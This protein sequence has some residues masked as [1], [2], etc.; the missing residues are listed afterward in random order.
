MS[1]GKITKNRESFP[2]DDTLLKLFYLA[3]ANVIKKWTMPLRDCK[4]ALT[5]FIIQFE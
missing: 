2:S 5:R 4:A 1:L 3:L